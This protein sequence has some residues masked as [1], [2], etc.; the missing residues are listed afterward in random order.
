MHPSQP[1]GSFINYE[2]VQPYA[3]EQKRVVS[4]SRENLFCN[5]WT[6]PKEKK[7]LSKYMKKI[8]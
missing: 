8:H 7:I 4:H 6:I 2:V 5:L 3:V 1:K